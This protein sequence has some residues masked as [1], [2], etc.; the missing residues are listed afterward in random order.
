MPAA[1]TLGAMAPATST[2]DGL[3]RTVDRLV[4]DH[5][6]D[7]LSPR[8]VVSVWS[9]AVGVAAG[10]QAL[11]PPAALARESTTPHYAA[12]TMKLPL[13]VAAYR[14]HERG[15][16]DL[17]ARVEVRNRFRSSVD[18]PAFSLRRDDDQDD[19]TWDR[20][21]GR[22]TIRELAR[23]AAVRSGN[24]AADLVHDQV[25]AAE[26][27]AV[28]RA[29]ACSGRTT[30]GRAIG[31]LAAQRAGQDNLVTAVDLARVM[32]GVATRTLVGPSAGTELEGL[33][34]AQQHREQI[35]AGL[36]PGTYVVDK[37]GWVPGVAHDI[38]LVRPGRYG[39]RPPYILAVCITA[40]AAEPTLFGLSA[41]I[42]AA[43]W[44]HW[45]R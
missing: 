17:D 19:E 29:A 7:G 32:H 4:E 8:P 2:A 14:L 15:G 33:L 11:T 9:G 5:L 38:A 21:G 30:V 37:P 27:E 13:L 24:L 23:Q 41:A 40:P 36:P 20:L 28:L 16:L 45:G 26:V 10:R 1:D 22:A 43:V 3:A 6:G 31:D 25:G 44:E 42:S 18:A 35:P 39:G 34:A 12:S